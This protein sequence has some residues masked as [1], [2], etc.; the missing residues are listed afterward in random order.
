MSV[1]SYT[2]PANGT[3]AFDPQ[4]GVFT[5]TPTSRFATA[6]DTFTYTITNGHRAY[7]TGTVTI[8]R[9]FWKSTGGG[10][11]DDASNWNSGLLPNSEDGVNLS[12]LSSQTVTIPSA[13]STTV[14]GLR[15]SG[16]TLQV[17][18][19]LTVTN[20]ADLAGAVG[21][22]ASGVIN[23]NTNASSGGSF[24]LSGGATV[25]GVLYSA[26]GSV[27]GL[28]GAGKV[29]A[30]TGT[31][32]LTGDGLVKVEQSAEMN[33]PNGDQQVTNLTVDT[34]SVTGQA[35]L[36][37]TGTLN[38]IGATFSGSVGSLVTLTGM[39][40][41]LAP[42]PGGGATIYHG[43]GFTVAE[44]ATKTISADIELRN[45]SKIENNGTVE[46]T[47]NSAIKNGVGGGQVVN[48]ATWGISAQAFAVEVPFVNSQNVLLQI[49]EQKAGVVKFTNYQ[50]NGPPD[51]PIHL[52]IPPSSTVRVGKGQF[53]AGSIDGGDEFGSGNFQVDSTLGPN[54]V[55]TLEI[56][57]TTNQTYIG[58]VNL[59]AD[60]SSKVTISSTAITGDLDPGVRFSGSKVNLQGYTT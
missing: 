30:L 55:G 40:F 41:I 14:W 45:G 59:T 20:L 46:V 57:G 47:A 29:Y 17:N 42:A 12:L 27:T 15:T 5:F 10:S 60:A 32:D 44:G 43:R 31:D 58:R 54:G 23:N 28:L 6:D 11:W 25:G 56:N 1:A 49:G 35:N 33:M 36:T 16:A 2:T 26:V 34:A 48:N 21:V 53:L 24:Q 50:Q 19:D 37:V 9:V 51:T 13:F 7:S 3:L 18:G 8:H 4:T 38:A 52:S 22:G 39:G